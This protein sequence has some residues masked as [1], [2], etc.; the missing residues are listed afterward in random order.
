MK[1]KKKE[2]EIKKERKEEKKKQ[3]EREKEKKQSKQKE[4]KLKEAREKKKEKR[5]ERKKQ[6]K[7]PANKLRQQFGDNQMTNQ[8]Q[9]PPTNN[10][11]QQ[12]LPQI[13]PP[14][15]SYYWPVG[16]SRNAPTQ[17]IQHSSTTAEQFLESETPYLDEDGYENEKRTKRMRIATPI[18]ARSGGYQSVYPNQ[19]FED[20]SQI[21][22]SS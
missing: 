8:Q 18:T 14:W 20:D 10:N 6:R 11:K 4:E 22:V 13:Q 5:K 16:N 15:P 19:S 17:G 12:Q 21:V 9:K 2:E 3:K 1:K 7:K